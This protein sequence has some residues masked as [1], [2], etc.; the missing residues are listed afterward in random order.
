[1][2]RRRFLLI[3]CAVLLLGVA[4]QAPSL[5]N[6]FFGDDYIQQAVLDGHM[7]A[8]VPLRPWNLYDFGGL[9]EWSE[10]SDAWTPIW[11][12]LPGWQI[13]FVRPLASAS[14]W[15]DH[16]VFGRAAWK[17]H[18]TSLVWYA[19]VLILALALLRSLGLG[20]PAALLGA[21]LYACTNGAAMPVGWI[22]N[23]NT[24][25]ATAATLAALLCVVRLR[26]RWRVA[27]ALALGAVAV[28]CKES[29]VTAFVL[30][31]VWLVLEA[32]SDGD[33][34]R[35]RRALAG[36]GLALAIAA[37]Y[38][39]AL[40]L[41][42][43]GTR[44]LFYATPWRE[45][46][47]YL[48]NLAVL[49]S[50]GLLRLVTPVSIDLRMML[51]GVGTWL[52]M[53]GALLACPV[54][55]AVWRRTRE[56]PAARFLAA[57]LVLSLAVEGSAPPSDRLLLQA[58]LGS[59]GLMALFIQGTLARGATGTGAWRREKALAWALVV[60][61]GV[62]SG[63]NAAA[64]SISL[65]MISRQLRERVL[66]TDVGPTVGRRLDA[67]VLQAADSMLPF[68]LTSTWWGEANRRDVRFS[69]FQMGRR[70]LEWTRE[71]DRTCT[72]R[73]TGA[74]FLTGLFET[75]FRSG[76]RMPPVG[77]RFISPLF[78][79]EVIEGGRAGPRAL[80]LDFHRSL[81]APDLRFLVP[82]KSGRL[83]PIAAPPVGTTI[84]LPESATDNPLLP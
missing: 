8:N 63:A 40:A 68:L 14:I 60:V 42:G 29:G 49:G 28:G 17:Y 23:R 22:A 44:S 72:L 55:F 50:A 5:W 47:R 19:I 15:L 35:R 70:G 67:V 13:R 41:A 79:A 2:D 78:T 53:A 71:S 82:D 16:A 34:G 11:W 18:V 74:P 27:A 25:L 80:R 84:R 4:V 83:R 81:D 10:K 59:A 61:A 57:W 54:A 77:Q 73:S 6:G 36:A 45:P 30:V 39:A 1:V 76:P 26:S 24:V 62:L 33:A 3:A 7:P 58:A 43:V 37:A 31:A 46:M 12:T 69:I 32:R 66:A 48:A 64:Q 51:P 75:V 56:H 38:L 20:R 21:A 65:T 52:T 9:R